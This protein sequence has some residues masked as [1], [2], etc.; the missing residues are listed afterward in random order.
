M[1]LYIDFLCTRTS[2]RASPYSVT[3]GGWGFAVLGDRG[4]DGLCDAW[5]TVD[6]GRAFGKTPIQNNLLSIMVQDGL[7]FRLRL[8]TGNTAVGFGGTRCYGTR[9]ADAR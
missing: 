9:L 7:C 1:V 4:R 8:G 2:I 3:G 6:C 5:V